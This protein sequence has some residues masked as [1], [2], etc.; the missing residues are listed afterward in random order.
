VDVDV[1]VVLLAL[2]FTALLIGVPLGMGAATWAVASTE[3]WCCWRHPFTPCQVAAL[4]RLVPPFLLGR[5]PSHA[6]GGAGVWC[7][8]RQYFRGWCATRTGPE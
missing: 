6:A 7:T 8:S 4:L 1:A 2:D 3:S 5:G